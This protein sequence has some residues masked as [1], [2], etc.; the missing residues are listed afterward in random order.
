MKIEDWLKQAITKLSDISTARLD[1]LVLLSDELG[2]DKSWILAHQ[3][4]ELSGNQVKTLNK[5]LARRIAHEPLAYIRG[6]TE[7]Y[8]REFKVNPHTLEPRPETETMIE[9]LLDKVKKERLKELSIVDVGTG[10]GCIAITIKLELPT[11]SV[12]ATDI[13]EKCIATAKE[14]ALRLG[15][16]VT[17]YQGDLLEPLPSSIFQL[18]TSGSAVLANLPYIPEA[19]HINESAQFEPRHAIFGGPDGLD[20]YKQL[21]LQISKLSHRP[22]CVLTE[23]LPFQHHNLA[24][25]A[26]SNGYTLINSQDFIQ[27]FTAD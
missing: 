20:L 8:G 10:S 9:L 25:I 15:S 16:D 24:Q 13:D 11:T 1:S 4:H 12:H 18:P 23:S 19:Y 2:K 21:F 6:K 3:E 14:N 7:F 5:K 17:F 27:I 22:S 26:R